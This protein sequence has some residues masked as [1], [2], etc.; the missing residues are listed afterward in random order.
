MIDPY[1][2]SRFQFNPIRQL[3]W[4]EIIK[5]ESKYIPPHAIIVDLGAGYCDFINMVHGQKRFAVDYSPE[6]EKYVGQGVYAVHNVVTDLS[7]IETGTV[8]IIHASNILEHLTDSEL[9]QTFSEICR[10]LK[11]Q[12]RIIIMQPNYFLKPRHYFDDPTHKKVFSHTA[13]RNF[14]VSKD[15]E[16]ILEKP[17]FLPFSMASHSSLIPRFLIPWIVRAYIYS[18]YKPFAGQMLFIAKKI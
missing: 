2:A 18:P 10:I 17:R 13:L 4:R 5:Y 16:I 7:P 1:Y 14:L 8:D 3:V 9:D 12:G 11:P 15:F 6:L